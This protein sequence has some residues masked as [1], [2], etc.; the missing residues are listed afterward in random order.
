MLKTQR[1]QASLRSSPAAI[2]SPVWMALVRRKALGRSRAFQTNGVER[3]P[4]RNA[5]GR[6]NE[7]EARSAMWPS[8]LPANA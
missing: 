6:L 4:S 3:A 2:L 1:F 7:I 5:K 8:A